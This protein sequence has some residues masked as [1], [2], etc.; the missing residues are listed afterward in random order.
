MSTHL[1]P[2]A[3]DAPE[4][5][6]GEGDPVAAP[7][8][9][10]ADMAAL[11]AAL[12]DGALAHGQPHGDATVLVPVGRLLEAVRFLKAHGYSLL[13]SVTAVDFLP[14]EPRFH[15][16]YHLLALPAAML[17]GDASLD[18]ADA[19]RAMRLKVPVPADAPVVPTLTAEFPTADWHEREVWDLFGI[20]FAGHPD[21]R[22]ILLPETFEGHP[23][24]KDHPLVYEEVAFTF[25][26]DQIAALKPRAT[27]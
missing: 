1:P 6:K 19:P 16:V 25:N 15:V 14:R 18:P 5:V 20:E 8:S 23:L 10:A 27:S 22:R 12:G 17:A 7:P 13:R 9:A 3:A 4:A 11:V 26:Q 2:G 21:P 24:R